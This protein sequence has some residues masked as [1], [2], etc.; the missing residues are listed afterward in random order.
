MTGTFSGF[1]IF[2]DRPHLDA[3]LQDE[4]LKSFGDDKFKPAKYQTLATFDDLSTIEYLTLDGIAKQH[5]GTLQKSKQFEPA[6]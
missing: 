6:L 4:K 5:E 1:V 2:K 3:F